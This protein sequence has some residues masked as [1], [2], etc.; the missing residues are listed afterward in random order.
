[1]KKNLILFTFFFISGFLTHAYF[2]P[3][4]LANGITTIPQL[5]M[6]NPTPTTTTQNETLITKV[7][8]DGQNFSRTNIKIGFTRYIQIINTSKDKLMWLQSNHP[9]LTTSRGYGESEAAQA[10]FNEKGQFVV[11]DKN[12]PDE[13]LVITVK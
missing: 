10:Q 5:V 9:E 4:F 3:D 13:R 8:F 1:M 6:P 7:Y 12:N 11:A 2:F